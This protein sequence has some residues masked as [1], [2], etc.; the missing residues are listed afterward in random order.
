MVATVADSGG[1]LRSGG[2]PVPL[3]KLNPDEATPPLAAS[4]PG[5]QAVF[6]HRVYT[7]TILRRR[8]HRC[9]LAQD[10]RAKGQ[11]NAGASSRYLRLPMER[12]T[13]STYTRAR[14]SPC[15]SIPVGWR[16]P[17]CQRPFWRMSAAAEEPAGVLYRR[18]VLWA[19]NFRLPRREGTGFA[20]LLAGQRRQYPATTGVAWRFTA[21]RAFRRRQ[22]AGV[23][24]GYQHGSG[25]LGERI[26]TGTL[27]LVSA[28]SPA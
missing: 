2:M 16:W 11:C 22:A 23:R 28:S 20:D 18:G 13:W 21:L 4:A 1:C 19:G 8:E 12:G 10:R 17:A 26:W 15:P 9:C 3:T 25:H 27:P 24:H 5:S 6:I 14:C 7:V